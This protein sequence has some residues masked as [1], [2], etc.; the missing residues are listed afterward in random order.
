MKL[1]VGL[2]LSG[3]ICQAQLNTTIQPKH[4]VI[5]KFNRNKIV[6]GSLVF[7]AGAAKGLNDPSIFTGKCFI[8]NSP[9]QAAAGTRRSAGKTNT[10]QDFFNY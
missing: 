3:F 7:I 4:E 8:K 5:W 6:T 1:L 10:N 9:T 2:L